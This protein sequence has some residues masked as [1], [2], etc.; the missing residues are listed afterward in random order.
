M[1][2]DLPLPVDY[3]H[4][5]RWQLWFPLFLRHASERGINR[6]ENCPLFKGYAVC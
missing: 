1:N 6:K 5:T 3:H 4:L 2:I